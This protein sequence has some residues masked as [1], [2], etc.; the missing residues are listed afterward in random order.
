[1][2][3]LMDIEGPG[4]DD[5]VGWAGWETAGIVTGLVGKAG[6]QG[7]GQGWGDGTGVAACSRQGFWGDKGRA[8]C[9]P[10]L[11]GRVRWSWAVGEAG[12]RVL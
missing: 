4:Q 9:R 2:A 6:Q 10:K 1:M 7:A 11:V 5:G 3:W 8:L 12:G